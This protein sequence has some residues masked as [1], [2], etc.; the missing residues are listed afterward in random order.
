MDASMPGEAMTTDH[1]ADSQTNRSQRTDDDTHECL[2][3]AS[4]VLQQQSWCLR[5]R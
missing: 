1:L 4:V 5:P 2:A 3:E